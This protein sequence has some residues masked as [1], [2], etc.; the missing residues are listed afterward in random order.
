L[1]AAS[2][3]QSARIARMGSIDAARRAGQTLAVSTTRARSTAVV[4]NAAPGADCR[5]HRELVRALVQLRHHQPADVHAAQDEDDG[6]QAL[7]QVERRGILA[8][9]PAMAT[10]AQCPACSHRVGDRAHFCDSCGAALEGE[11]APTGTAYPAVCRVHDVGE[12]DGQTFLSKE[13]VDG[14]DLS[15][16]RRRIGRLPRDKALEIA[17]QLAPSTVLVLGCLAALTVYAFRTAVGRPL[18]RAAGIAAAVMLAS[19]PSLSAAAAPRG[20]PSWDF[21]HGDLKVSP[22]RRFL[23]HADGTPFLY[24]GDTA[25]ELFHRLDREEATRYLEMRR[26]Q[27][28]TVIQAV[29]LAEFEG[30]DTPNA[31]GH[32]PLLER[33]PTRPDVQPGPR[34]DYWDHVDEIVAM[35]RERGLYLGLL[36]T[37][38]DKAGPRKW[39]EGPIIFN[40]DNARTYGR[41]LGE[42]YK[43]APNVIWILGGDR[44]AVDEKEGDF[45]AVWHAMAAGLEEGDGGRHLMTYHPMGGRSSSEWFQEAPWLDFNMLQSGH[46]A[47]NLANYRMIAADYL[48]VPTRPVLDGEPRYEDHPVNWKPELGWFD[49]YDVRQAA[50]WAL[51]AGAFGHTYGCHDVWQMYTLARK[52]VSSARTDWRK[53]INLPGAWQMGHLRRLLLSRPFLSRVPDQSLVPGGRGEGADHVM[54]TRDRDGAYAFVYVPTGQPVTLDL[55]RM[56]GPRVK[57]W[58]FDPRTGEAAAA[59]EWPRERRHE[60]R[61]P[62]T[63]GRGHDWVLVL[64]DAGRGF[65]PPGVVR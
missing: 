35:A 21:S 54:A 65:P 41:F 40:P 27:G 48:R 38:G 59:G 42:R 1:E 34:N 63:A 9:N 7:H 39:G 33:D 10:S 58:W 55:T 50:Y 60:F 44:P 26:R 15:A 17:R 32:R 5:P 23:V 52:P 37:W 57:A 12:V 45:R 47:K 43:D 19:A 18:P 16:R 4:P 25:W 62:G 29:L 46:G 30:L 6:D 61:P 53:A 64:D 3:G 49:A 51:F 28:F 14:E 13:Y 8:G 2:A 24:L 22:D 20:A 11:G 31:Y 56:A 36:P